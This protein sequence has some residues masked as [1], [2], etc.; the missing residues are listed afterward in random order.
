LRLVDGSIRIDVDAAEIGFDLVEH[1]A[2]RVRKSLR[3]VRMNAKSGM[4]NI[5]NRFREPT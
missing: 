5:L 4:P 3:N 2:F 1:S